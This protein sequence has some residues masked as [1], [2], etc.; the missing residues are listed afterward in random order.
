MALAD[1]GLRFDTRAS[2]VPHF[3]TDSRRDD[4]SAECAAEERRV[5]AARRELRPADRPLGVLVDRDPIVAVHRDAE[6]PRRTGGERAHRDLA[7]AP[8]GANA[9]EDERQ[10]GLE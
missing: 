1:E 7:I 8:S 6:D 5:L 10:R 4:A 2:L 3:P 9:A